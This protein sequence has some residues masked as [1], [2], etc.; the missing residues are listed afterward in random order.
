[1][2]RAGMLN[3]FSYTGMHNNNN[4]EFQ[5]WKQDYHP[6]QLDTP[7]KLKQRLDYLPNNPVSSGLFGNPGIINTAA[8]LIIILMNMGY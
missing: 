3:I 1:M 5:F 2:E 8:L 4:K 7:D 6:I